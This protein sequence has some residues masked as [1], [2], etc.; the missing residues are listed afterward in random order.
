MGLERSVKVVKE[1]KDENEAREVA[2]RR[3]MKST[4]RGRSDQSLGGPH[5]L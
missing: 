4:S 2:A 5:R 3:S 1:E